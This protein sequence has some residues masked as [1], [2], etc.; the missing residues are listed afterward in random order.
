MKQLVK[1][2]IPLII[3]L[4]PFL[5]GRIYWDYQISPLDKK[6]VERV[7][8]IKQ[9]EGISTIAKRLKSE[10]FIRSDL[11]FKLVYKFSS[12]QNLE[13]GDF[14][15]SP[16][17]GVK[18]IL[19]EL[20]SGSLDKWV[21]IIEGLRVEEV[22]DRLSEK[23]KAKRE[24]FIAIA[25]KHEGYLFPDTYL[26][27][28]DV[29]EEDI[30]SKLL[31]N[32]DEKFDTSLQKKINHLGLTSKEGVILASIVEREARSDEARKMVASILLKRFK[33]GMGLNADATVQYGLGY[34][35][36][37]NSWWKRHLSNDDLKVDSPYNTYLYNGLPPGPICNPSLSSL[38]AV[39]NADPATPYLYYYHSSKGESFYGRTLEEHNVNIESNP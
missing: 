15:L 1:L 22:A 34:Q 17:Q 27:N 6:G 37:E 25:K 30:V 7:F 19:R 21:T 4:L 20:Q 16:A 26:F 24:K 11:V 3:L 31:A 39:A 10:G 18:Q 13:A 33:I 36:N 9:G 14:K 32:F 12:E 23:L 5:I 35:T 38:Q 28:P 8:V 29:L 2:F